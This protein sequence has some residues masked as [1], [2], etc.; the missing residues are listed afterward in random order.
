MTSTTKTLSSLSPIIERSLQELIVALAQKENWTEQK[1]WRLL[2]GILTLNE[3][4]KLIDTLSK[5]SFFKLCIQKY[6][7]RPDQLEK[8]VQQYYPTTSATKPEPKKL[9]WLEGIGKS[10]FSFFSRSKP[11]ATSLEEAMAN[12]VERA[13]SSSFAWLCGL[14][15]GKKPVISPELFEGLPR[16]MPPTSPSLKM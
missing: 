3:L 9:S 5:Q 6:I 12:I 13:H 2:E 10:F 1:R 15:P 8:L 14:I 16:P 11:A 4:S 7:L